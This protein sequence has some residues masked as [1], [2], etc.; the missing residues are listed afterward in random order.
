MREKDTSTNQFRML[1]KEV[2]LLMGY[3]VTRKLPLRTEPIETPVGPAL[4]NYIAG[5]KMVIVPIPGDVPRSGGRTGDLFA[6]HGEQSTLHF[7]VAWLL[8]ELLLAWK[9]SSILKLE[10]YVGLDTAGLPREVD[11]RIG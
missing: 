11:D 1:L 6:H 3:E 7:H 5:K 9:A 8:E 4:G 10:R 2:A